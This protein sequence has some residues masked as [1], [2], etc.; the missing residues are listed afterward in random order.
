MLTRWRDRHGKSP[1]Q[2]QAKKVVNSA[3]D[4]VRK[5]FTD[6]TELGLQESVWT[7]KD[8]KE[9]KVFLVGGNSMFKRVKGVNKRGVIVGRVSM[10]MSGK[11]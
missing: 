4:R 11:Q 5:D 2:A 10:G 8:D 9:G 3:Q 6:F 1:A 7:T